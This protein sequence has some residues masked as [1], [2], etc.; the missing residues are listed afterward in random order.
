MRLLV[1]EDE[2]KM[3]KLLERGLREEGHAV[4]VT[5]RGEDALWMARAQPHSVVVSHRCT[6]GRHRH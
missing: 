4:D 1:V 2:A 5:G 6:I 3:A